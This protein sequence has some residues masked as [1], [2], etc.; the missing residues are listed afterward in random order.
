MSKTSELTFAPEH[1]QSVRYIERARSYYLGLGYENP[2]V[3]A[4]YVDV[5]FTPL[6]KPL[7]QSVLSLITTVVP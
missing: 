6:K 1:D 5:P 2:Y 3:W 7:S 4:H